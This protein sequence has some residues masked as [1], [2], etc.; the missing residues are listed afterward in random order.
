MKMPEET[1][2]ETTEETL[3]DDLHLNS[4][5]AAKL[6]TEM[7]KAAKEQ[8][9]RHNEM[10]VKV[11]GKE[12]DLRE[13]MGRD[14]RNIRS[15]EKEYGVKIFTVTREPNAI[16]VKGPR[17]AAYEAKENLIRRLRELGQRR[18][19]NTEKRDER[20]NIVCRF[21]LE[22]RCQKGSR[23]FFRHTRDETRREE[24]NRERSRSRGE[25]NRR[26]VIRRREEMHE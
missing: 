20:K 4:T 14:G 25:D 19:T 5:H 17:A 24:P 22:N 9:D 11:R 1:E 26:V 15:L 21:F 6:A 16:R 13:V 12:E 8:G 10:E 7:T 23:C 18:T 3:E 2:N